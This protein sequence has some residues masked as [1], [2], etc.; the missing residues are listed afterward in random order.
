MP[1]LH[2]GAVQFGELDW[3]HEIRWLAGPDATAAGP[4]EVALR[5]P[6]RAMRDTYF[7]AIR[8][9]E[10][11]WQEKGQEPDFFENYYQPRAFELR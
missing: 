1:S 4:D 11:L 2:Y 8:Q 5:R 6:S 3:R 7:Q 9:L 10:K